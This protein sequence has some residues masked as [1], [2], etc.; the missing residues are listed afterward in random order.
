MISNAINTVCRATQ[1]WE[2]S[3][4][5]SFCRIAVNIKKKKK[6]GERDITNK[7]TEVIY[8]LC[9]WDSMFMVILLIKLARQVVR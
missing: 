4:K 1:V 8:L 3:K 5:G 7:M 6:M 2:I 9:V